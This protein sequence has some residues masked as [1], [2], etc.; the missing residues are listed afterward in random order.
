[1]SAHLSSPDL[2]P[3]TYV[4]TDD[5]P[6]KVLQRVKKWMSDG[7]IKTFPIRGED[8]ENLIVN[9]ANVTSVRVSNDREIPGDP[10]RVE[11]FLN[12]IAQAE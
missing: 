10:P 7:E 2:L 3:Y 9:F 11:I 1:M 5:N 6:A 12:S 8:D 4:F